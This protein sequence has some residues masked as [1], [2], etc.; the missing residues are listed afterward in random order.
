MKKQ[1]AIT[2]YCIIRNGIVARNGQVTN[3]E[4]P[5]FSEFAKSLYKSMEIN[6]PKFFKMDNLSKLGFLAAEFLLKNTNL[7]RDASDEIGVVIANSSSSLDTDREF[8]RTI[9]NKEDYFP[10]PAV[11]VYTLPNILTGE[12]CIRHNLK[13]ENAFFI[14]EEFETD[15][16]CNYVAGLMAAGNLK[17]CITG[18]VELLECEYEAALFLIEKENERAEFNVPFTPGNLDKIY[19]DKQ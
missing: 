3:I 12:I 17:A 1:N 19:W 9:E 16:I 14:F 7:N 5:G 15:F 10:S 2:S 13:G 18:W 11:F 8:Y 4:N 6:Y